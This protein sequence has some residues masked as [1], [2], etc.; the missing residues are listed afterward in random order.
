MLPLNVRLRLLVLALSLGAPLLVHAQTLRMAETLSLP[1]PRAPVKTPVHADYIVAVVNSEPI[2]NNEVQAEVQRVSQQM[3]MQR[4]AVP[5]AKEL[6]RQ[7]LD[8]LINDRIQLQMARENGVR[9]DDAAVDQAEQN[10]AR[11]NQLDVAELHRRVQADGM[12]LTQYRAQLRDQL[13]LARL[14]EREVEGRVRVSDLEID[15]YLKDQQTRVDPANLELSLAQ[16]LIAVPDAATPEQV[17]TLQTKAQKVLERAKAG[18]DF[19]A[20]AREFSEGAE[21]ANGGQMGLRTGNRYPPLFLQA[22]QALAAGELS[23]LVRSGAGFHVL[24]VLEKK[25]SSLPASTISQTRSRH[26]LLR[27]G[28]QLSEAAAR[29][30]L[31]DLRK[32]IVSAAA[33]FAALARDYSQ[34]GSAALG[35]DLG[36]ASAG[37]FVPE[38]EEVLARLQPGQVS[39]PFVSRFGLHLVQ[40]NERR[41]VTLSQREQRDLVRA[42]LRDKKLEEAY[43]SWTQEQR[44]RAYVE[45]REAP[46]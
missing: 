33:D 42:L 28:P 26:I 4:R 1:M 7:V 34:D 32:R 3:A 6:S 41:T 46:Q 12:T 17:A 22:T 23:D 24:K 44:G 9:I 20:L 31:Q 13:T 30:R 43:A 18:E 15:Q 36:W 35:G 40:L 11:Q 45:M 14:R 25:N 10:I 21:R 38:F 2:T 19:A 37:M 8:R 16:I 39:E 29:E 5:D 27:P